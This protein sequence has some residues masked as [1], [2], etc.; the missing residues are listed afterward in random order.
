MAQTIALETGEIARFAPG[1]NDASYCR[2]V[3]STQRSNGKR[4]GQGHVKNGHAYLEGASREAAPFAIRF[5]P[6]VHRFYQRKAAKH[7]GLVARKSVAPKLARA[8]L[9]VIRDQVPFE[10]ERAFG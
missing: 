7:Q 4:K 5:H 9:Y 6:K 3:R 8:C 2:C 1:G 10:V